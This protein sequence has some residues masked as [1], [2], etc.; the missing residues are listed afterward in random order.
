MWIAWGASNLALQFAIGGGVNGGERRAGR[1][2]SLGIRDTTRR[3]KNMEELVALTPDAAEEPQFL[4]NHGPG[5][6][7]KQKQNEKNAA[8]D[9][10]G[11]RKDVSDIVLKNSGEQKN[12]VPL[13]ENKFFLGTKNVAYASRGCNQ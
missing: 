11:L 10:A 12:V 6:Q 4:K 3:P 13:S 8:G 7:R 9:Q 5:N 2:Q 1:G